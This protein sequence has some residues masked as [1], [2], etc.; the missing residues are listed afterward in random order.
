MTLSSTNWLRSCPTCVRA[1]VTARN[2]KIEVCDWFHGSNF[3]LFTTADVRYGVIWLSHRY[4]WLAFFLYFQCLWHCWSG[5]TPAPWHSVSPGGGVVVGN[6]NADTFWSIAYPDG[7]V[8]WVPVMWSETVG[9]RTRPVW[10]QKIGLGLAHCGLGLG[11]AGLVLLCEK[12]S[13]HARRHNDLEGHGN[14]SSTIYSSSILCLE[15]HYC[16]DQQWHSHT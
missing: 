1:A 2:E 15:H 13:C 4:Y 16:G 9:L 7:T 12:R 11:L 5:F 6:T 14:F 8:W 3:C 10:D